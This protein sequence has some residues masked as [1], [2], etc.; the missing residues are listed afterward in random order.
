MLLPEVRILQ[1]LGDML[2]DD[3]RMAVI[4]FT[5]VMH[6]RL[7][8]H[9]TALPEPTFAVGDSEN[10][11]WQQ[12]RPYLGVFVYQPE[13]SPK[14]MVGLGIAIP[15]KM[16]TDFERRVTVSDFTIAKPPVSIDGLRLRL[17]ARYEHGIN[18]GP[19][20]SDA[21]ARH[22]L[23]ALRAE[24]PHL[25]T[26]L[27][28]LIGLLGRQLP[29]SQARTIR[30]HEKDG[31]N[32]LLRASG[33]DHAAI[34]RQAGLISGD[35]PYLASLPEEI[36]IS[37]HDWLHFADW[38]GQDPDVN[39]P[40]ARIYTSPVVEARAFGEGPQKLVIYNANNG[41]VENMSGVDLMYYNATDKSF[42]MVQ[43]KDFAIEDSK[44]V[45]RP[46]ARL[47]GQ[48]KR[49]QQIDE[50]CNPSTNPI[51]IRLHHKPCFLKLCDP[52]DIG[53]DSVDMLKGM[54]LTREHF[55][56]ILNS[57]EARGPRGGRVI[58][59]MT[60]PRHLDND[61]FTRL[62]GYGWIG[63]SGVSTDF[64]RQ[65]VW[66]SLLQRGSVVIGAHLGEWP[67]G[68]GYGRLR[69]ADA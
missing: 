45:I 58:G 51:D 28:E 6:A 35:G 52:G 26:K 47:D 29:D 54:Y 55:E 36:R 48:L 22:L 56:V 39:V 43:Y 15:G 3:L 57:R 40:G 30:G 21:T 62:L 5:E 25:V 38:T 69:S 64:V 20:A 34:L 17:G 14:L 50:Q 1:N 44:K 12:R 67:L 60:P 42:I 13:N 65:Q 18:Y 24:A 63:S 31:I 8:A 46:N 66:D 4:P 32:T 10:N 19:A 23:A 9:R 59:K 16:G 2:N 33:H 53:S 37:T 11:A 7:I 27:D 41:V 68:N 49:M 61:T